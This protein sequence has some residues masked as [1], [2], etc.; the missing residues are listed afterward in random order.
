VF[1]FVLGAAFLLLL[2]TFRSLV[3]PI[4]AIVLKPAQRRRRLRRAGRAVPAT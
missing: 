2:V 3:I 1:G 4:K